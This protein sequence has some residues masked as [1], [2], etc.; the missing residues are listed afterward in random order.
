MTELMIT[1]KNF[2]EE[3]L[4]SEIPVLLD[5][6]ADWCGP[7]MMLSPIVE[8]IAEKYKGKVKVGK[9]NVDDEP[10][11]AQAF[12]VSS[13][14]M[15]FVIKDKNVVNAAVGYKSPEQIEAMISK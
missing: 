15:L 9:I 13:I 5:F 8:E 1:N 11:L 3:V 10:E 12:Q 14:P 4:N 2:E 6:W 7:C